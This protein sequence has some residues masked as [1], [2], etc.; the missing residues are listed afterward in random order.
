MKVVTP[1]RRITPYTKYHVRLANEGF[2]WLDAIRMLASSAEKRSGVATYALTNEPLSVPHYAYECGEQE[3]M[4]WLLEVCACYL[5]SEQFDQNTVCISPDS[6]VYRH[7][8]IFDGEFDIAFSCRKNSPAA[9]KKPLMNGAQ[10]WSHAAKDRLAALFRECLEMARRLPEGLRR[11]GADTVPLLE[12]L[13]P[14]EEGIWSRHGITVRYL[15]PGSM[16][17]MTTTTMR[18]EKMGAPVRVVDFKGW[19][20][21]LMR[22][23]FA[24]EY[25]R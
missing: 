17:T 19:S 13:G 4:L 12:L 9:E 6:L 22:A 10:W 16:R 11:W 2:D 8:D 15:P 20:K 25:G 7:L 1:Y 5:E 21:L 14:V 23:Y 24:R 3:L 18:K